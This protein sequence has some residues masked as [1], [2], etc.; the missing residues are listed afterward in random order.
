MQ[1]GMHRTWVFLSCCCMVPLN[2]WLLDWFLSWLWKNSCQE[3][4]LLQFVYWWDTIYRSEECMVHLEN[5][6]DVV[7]GSQ[8][9]LFTF[10]GTRKEIKYRKWAIVLVA[11]AFL[12]FFRS[13]SPSWLFYNLPNSAPSWRPSVQ[14][15][16]Q[17]GTCYSWTVAAYLGWHRGLVWICASC[18]DDCSMSQCENKLILL[19]KICCTLFL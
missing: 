1:R 7:T 6:P 13:T 15:H 3:A 11:R 19:Q 9:S 10:P 16:T 8:D 14:T 18:T 12:Q 17:V 5:L 2:L 4:T